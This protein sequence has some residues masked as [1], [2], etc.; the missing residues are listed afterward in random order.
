MCL[1]LVG[2]IQPPKLKKKMAS[3]LL[4]SANAPGPGADA[5]ARCVDVIGAQGPGFGLERSKSN[6]ILCS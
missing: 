6:V 4:E 2:Q 1:R 3:I 5:N